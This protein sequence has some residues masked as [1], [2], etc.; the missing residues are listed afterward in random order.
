MQIEVL[1]GQKIQLVQ[2][3]EQ[4]TKE[5]DVAMKNFDS[6]VTVVR[7]KKTSLILGLPCTHPISASSALM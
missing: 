1:Q 2:E 6:A 7:E 3:K 5:R 4:V